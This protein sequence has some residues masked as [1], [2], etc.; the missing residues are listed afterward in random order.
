LI[1]YHKVFGKQ[2][3]SFDPSCDIKTIVDA[4]AN[5]GTSSVYF[6]IKYPA[7][8]VYAIE[9]ERHNLE[10]LYLNVS[11]ITNIRVIEGAI[12]AECNDRYLSL[13]DAAD[14]HMLASSNEITNLSSNKEINDKVV[15]V[16]CY[17]LQYL[18]Q[19]YSLTRID[20]LKID[21]EGGEVAVLDQKNAWIDSVKSIAIEPHSFVP[22]SEDSVRSLEN[23]F[24]RYLVNGENHIFSLPKKFQH[25]ESTTS[26]NPEIT[27]YKKPTIAVCIPT[28]NQACFLT[29]AV[30]SVFS[31]TFTPDEIWI[32]DDASTDSTQGVVNGLQAIYPKI[33]YYRQSQRLG[34]SGNPRWVVQQATTDFILK[35]DSDDVLSPLYL[36]QLSKSLESYPSA[37]Y[38]HCDVTFISQTGIELEVRQLCRKEHYINSCASLK[39]SVKGFKVTANIILYRRRALEEVGYFRENMPFCDDWDIG[40]RLADNGWGNV[41]VPKNLASYRIWIDEQGLRPRRIVDKIQGSII[42]YN[43]SLVPAF[44]RKQWDLSPIIRSRQKLA[45][46]LALYLYK[47]ELSDNVLSY[48]MN[49]LALLSPESF[50]YPSPRLKAAPSHGM[51]HT[52]DSKLRQLA[53]RLLILIYRR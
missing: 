40:V 36:E 20:I 45:R 29:E 25:F 8:V 10:I 2:E 14:A 47:A 18:F 43:Q 27:C 38:A 15:K 51:M 17:S 30:Q 39:A 53:R 28:Y 48:G 44:L 46:N 13:A 31:Q 11:S 12:D 4:G 34:M 6:S 32:S 23:D 9:P 33:S 52:I 19:C 22:H 41:Y 37:G 5:I 21:I 7:S 50:L 26:N 35:L 3:Y 24:S 1:A 16:K 42:V 49:L